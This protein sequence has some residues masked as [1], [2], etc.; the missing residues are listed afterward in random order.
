MNSFTA[1]VPVALDEPPV[2]VLTVTTTW[3]VA[4][5]A[6]SA[7]ASAVSSPFQFTCTLVAG[8]PPKNTWGAGDA[9]K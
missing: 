6:G 3:S 4:F 7:G 9:V 5:P 1:G 8:T 2:V